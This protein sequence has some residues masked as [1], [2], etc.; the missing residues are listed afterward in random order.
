MEKRL[1]FKESFSDEIRQRQSVEI[2]QNYDETI[3]IIV[4]KSKTSKM[5]EFDRKK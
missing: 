4:E 5:K 1:S 2:M 3:P